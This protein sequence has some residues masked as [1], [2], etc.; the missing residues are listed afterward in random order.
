M[1]KIDREGKLRFSPFFDEDENYHTPFFIHISNLFEGKL[2]AKKKREDKILNFKSRNIYIYIC[3]IDN[4]DNFV[5]NALL[6]IFFFHLTEL[7]IIF[8]QP[9]FLYSKHPLQIPFT[10][11]IFLFT[12]G[13]FSQP[14][15][16]PSFSVNSSLA[17]FQIYIHISKTI[18]NNIIPLPFLC[19]QNLDT[20]TVST[21]EFLTLSLCRNKEKSLGTFLLEQVIRETDC[22]IR[23][24]NIF[25]VV[26]S[27]EKE[28][29]KRKRERV[30]RFRER[31]RGKFGATR[32]GGRGG[33]TVDVAEM[34]TRSYGG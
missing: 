28:E 12:N 20:F 29:K 4:I 27:Y 23:G 7:F 13:I 9:P 16:R 32:G 5:R 30:E 8:Q 17:N 22:V 26:A 1:K 2:I 15:A 25:T 33:R 6:F 18:T 14:N 11:I 19:N 10:A 21:S 3:I 24:P 31:K 34:K